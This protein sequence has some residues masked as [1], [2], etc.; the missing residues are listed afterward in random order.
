MVKTVLDYG[1]KSPVLFRAAYNP[2]S[3]LYEKLKL[4]PLKRVFKNTSFR[5]VTFVKEDRHVTLK[6]SEAF[7]LLPP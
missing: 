2:L 4:K 7:F 3:C 1:N 5:F 6:D